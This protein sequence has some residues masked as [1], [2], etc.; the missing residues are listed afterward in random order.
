MEEF[1]HY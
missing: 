1:A